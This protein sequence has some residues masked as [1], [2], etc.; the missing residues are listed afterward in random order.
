MFD[1]RKADEII[2]KIQ[3]VTRLIGTHKTNIENINREKDKRLREYDD[4]IKREE[5]EITRLNKQMT[6]QL[7]EL[8]KQLK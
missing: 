3:D 7:N 5:D 8:Q 2:R 6:E 4:K 1:P